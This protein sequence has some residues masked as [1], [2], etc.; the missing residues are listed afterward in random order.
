[1]QYA[2]LRKNGLPLTV[3]G[4]GEINV[5][6]KRKHMLSYFQHIYNGIKY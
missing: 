1:M 4:I 3:N 2:N 6:I 5:N